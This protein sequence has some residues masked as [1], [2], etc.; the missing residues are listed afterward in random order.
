MYRSAKLLV[1]GPP[2]T[3]R[4]RKNRL[5]AVDGRLR[6]KKRIRRRRRGKEEIRRGEE[7]LLSPRRPRVVVARGSPACHPRSRAILLSRKETERL[8]TRGKRLR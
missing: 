1:R 8:P 7:D 4:Y 2:A 5:S 3:E 6:E